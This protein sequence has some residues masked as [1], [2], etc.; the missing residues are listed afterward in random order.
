MVASSAEF[1][2]PPEGRESQAQPTFRTSAGPLATRAYRR[3]G[4][5]YPRSAIAC[6]L[7]L[8]YVVFLGGAAIVPTYVKASVGQ[9][10]LLAAWRS[11]PTLMPALPVLPLDKWAAGS[12]AM[13]TW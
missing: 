10:A 13:G 11:R 4:P 1:A 3:L 7:L 5:R 12:L 8:F 6:G 2:G 9:F